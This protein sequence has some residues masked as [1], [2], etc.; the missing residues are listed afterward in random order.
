MDIAII[1]KDIWIKWEEQILK[2]T[3]SSKIF[4][5]YKYF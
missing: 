5:K 3:L 4:T 1:S 2:K